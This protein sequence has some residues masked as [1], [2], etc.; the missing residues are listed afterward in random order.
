M[1]YLLDKQVH[2]INYT[3]FQTETLLLQDLQKVRV[4]NQFRVGAY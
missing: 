3:F 1:I 2:K 4:G